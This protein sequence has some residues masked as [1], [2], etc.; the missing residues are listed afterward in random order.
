LRLSRLTSTVKGLCAA[1]VLAFIAAPVQAEERFVAQ[2]QSIAVSVP[3]PDF[4]ARSRPEVSRQSGMGALGHIVIDELIPEG[5]SFENWSSLYAIKLE[6]G[7]DL[8]LSQYV[9]QLKD[10]YFGA[11][12][13]LA[14]FMIMPLEDQPA[15]SMFVIPCQSYIANPTQGE[16]AVFVI[17]KT[18]D[19]FIN[20]YQHWRGPAFMGVNPATWPVSPQQ[21]DLFF[22][23]AADIRV[24]RR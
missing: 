20:V 13:D 9:G 5:E 7:I 2:G 21:L 15:L 8:T 18:G 12:E 4:S 11:C 6:E 1:S 22:A 14:E 16:V 24:E 10:I 23:N 17:L 19:D 3:M